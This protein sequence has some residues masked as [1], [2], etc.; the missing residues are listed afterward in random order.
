MKTTKQHDKWMRN[1]DWIIS[2]AHQYSAADAF[3]DVGPARH[4]AA[5]KLLQEDFER[6]QRLWSQR[7]RNKS[8]RASITHER[9][10]EHAPTFLH[11]RQSLVADA[12]AEPLNQNQGTS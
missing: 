9:R 5:Y 10:A 12:G 1:V 11:V 2:K 3:E 6:Q 8:W 4:H 7:R